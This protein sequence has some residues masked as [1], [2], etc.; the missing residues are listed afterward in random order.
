M[1][2]LPRHITSKTHTLEDVYSGKHPCGVEGDGG[3]DIQIAKLLGM[4]TCNVKGV[5]IYARCEAD[6]RPLIQYLEQGGEYGSLEFSR[7]LGYSPIEIAEYANV[8][9][10]HIDPIGLKMGR[11]S[12]RIYKYNR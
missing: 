7:L 2:T 12:A 11:I 1:P 9:L 3:K 5:D 4:F 10:S 6:A 8:I